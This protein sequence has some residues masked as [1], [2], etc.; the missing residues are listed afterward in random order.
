MLTVDERLLIGLKMLEKLKPNLR[1][2]RPKRTAGSPFA[3]KRSSETGF[4]GEEEQP[5]YEELA[6]P[7]LAGLL[8]A[9]GSLPSGSVIL[10]AC[11][12]GLPFLFD[13]SNPAPGALLIA[14]DHVSGKTR[15]LRAILTSAIR[16]NGPGQL[17]INLV[18]QFPEEYS[19]LEQ[20]PNL[21][22]MRA[23]YEDAAVERLDALVEVVE[24]RRRGNLHGPAMLLVIDDLDAW[25]TFLSE[26]SFAHLVWLVRHGPRYRVWTIASLAAEQSDRVDPRLLAA[27]RTR[28]LG[29]IASPEQA[30][31]LAGTGL[32]RL[33]EIRSGA[34]FA[35]PFGDEWV[36]FYICDD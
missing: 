9:V 4:A 13:L 15:L 26:E 30:G 18:A 17:Q 3:V 12:D 10:G 20:A 1:A 2:A 23:A 29:R 34:E 6:S 32:P 24:R 36:R 8:D 19:G 35:V 27:F 14:G 33:P 31:C 21:Q 16:L 22:E 25:L 7:S 5:A 28:L 11:E